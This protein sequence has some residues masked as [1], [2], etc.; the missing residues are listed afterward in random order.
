MKTPVEWTNNFPLFEID[1]D[2]LQKSSITQEVLTAQTE[3]SLF[4]LIAN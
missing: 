4:K 2:M 1:I 3:L